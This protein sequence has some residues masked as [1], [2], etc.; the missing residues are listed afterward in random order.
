MINNGKGVLRIGTS[1]I[2]VPGNKANFPVEFQQG[3]RLNYYSS[4]FNTVEIN[5]SFY[6]VPMA[7]TFAR[8][9]T[10]VTPDFRFSVK[11]W[12]GITH[13]KALAFDPKDI[14]NFLRS[15]DLLGDTKGSLLIQF[16]KS[17]TEV[18]LQSLRTIMEKVSGWPMAIE[19]RY[20]G[21]YN[22]EVYSLLDEFGASVVLHDM[23]GSIPEKLNKKAPF[24]F[25]RFH[26]ETGNYRGTYTPEHLGQKADQ[27]RSWL[28]AGKDVYAY[29]NNTIGEAYANA[30]SLKELVEAGLH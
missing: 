6:K 4:L 1:G 22:K 5:S 12:K 28:K 20:P 14:D 24:V 15:A 7:R 2:V 18:H 23:P 27:I 19:F 3:S 21:W 29:F 30:L 25:I 17:I 11:L 13:A 10:E 9:A 26:G 16:P 8:W